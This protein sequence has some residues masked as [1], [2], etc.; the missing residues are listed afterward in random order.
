MVQKS[1]PH[2]GQY[3]HGDHVMLWKKR[4]EADRYEL[5]SRIATT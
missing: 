5:L 3:F 1:R 2:R 4:G